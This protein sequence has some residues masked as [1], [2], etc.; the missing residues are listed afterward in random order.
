MASF[1]KI[2]SR[3]VLKGIARVSAYLLLGLARR[4][5]VDV[6]GAD[7]EPLCG[8]L[9]VELGVAAEGLNRAPMGNL[10]ETRSIRAV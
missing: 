4:G 1:A 3:I 2:Q 9:T 10:L 6:D 7:D 5:A 8:N